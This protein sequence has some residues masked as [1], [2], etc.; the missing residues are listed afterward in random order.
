MPPDLPTRAV[1][2]PVNEMAVQTRSQPSRLGLHRKRHSGCL[3]AAVV[4]RSRSNSIEVVVPEG[5]LE[6]EPELRKL[7]HW[8]ANT[9]WRTRR[10]LGW[11][12]YRNEESGEMPRDGIPYSVDVDEVPSYSPAVYIPLG[13]PYAYY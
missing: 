6:G 7:L 12:F 10:H 11:G 1:F 8:H 3:P 4:L 5:A 9:A 13:F 2:E